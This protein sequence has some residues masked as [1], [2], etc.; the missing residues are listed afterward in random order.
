MKGQRM[1]TA[2]TDLR[3]AFRQ[4]RRSPALALVAV[5]SLALGSGANSAVFSVVDALLL[6]PLPYAQ[7]DQLMMVFENDSGSPE[8]TLPFSPPDFFDFQRQARSFSGLEGC[9]FWSYNIS[10]SGDPERVI[11]GVVTAGLFP[12]L[13]RRP[14]LGRTFRPEEDQPGGPPVVMLGFGLWQRRFG[15]DPAVL[16][17]KIQLDNKPYTI[18]GVMPAGFDFPQQAEIWTLLRESRQGGDRAFQYLRGVGRL[19]PGVSVATARAEVGT[20]ARRLERAYP[21]TNRG[22]GA[23]LIPLRERLVGDFRAAL[24]I[25]FGAV[26]LLL[27]V[28]CVNIANLLLARAARRQGEFAVRGALG[29]GKGRLLRQL[30]TESLLLALAGGGLGLLLAR[31]LTQVL[32]KLNPP[33]IFLHNGEPLDLRGATVDSRVLAFTLAVAVGAGILFGLAPALAARRV[34]LQRTLAAS[35]DRLSGSGSR[36]F[37][38]LAAAEVAVTFTLLIGAGLVLQSFLRL[39]SIDPGFKPDHLLTLQLTLPEGRYPS[40]AQTSGFVAQVLERCRALPGV[41]AAAEMSTL[42]LSNGM[43][44]DTS[45]TVVGEPSPSTGKRESIL[46]RAVSPEYFR[47]VGIPLRA[48]RPLAAQDDGRAPLAVAVNESLARRFFGAKSPIGRRIALAVADLGP[49]G[50]YTDAPREVVAVVGDVKDRRLDADSH[51]EVYLPVAQ[52]PWRSLGFVV[53]T[54]GDPA[55]MVRPVSRQVWAVDPN[56]PLY[57]VRTMD[58]IVSA[59]IAQPRFATV[60]LSAFAVLAIFLAIIGIYGVLSY[61][62]AQRSRELG[63]RMALGA[64]PRDVLRHVLGWS[65]TLVAGGIAV[66]LVASLALT[67]LLRSLVFGVTTTDVPTFLGVTVLLTAVAL[68]A[69]LVPAWRASRLSPITTLRSF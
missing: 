52:N 44:V 21:D 22:R 45:L 53:R 38:L 2:W 11:G 32:V 48:G 1:Q 39:R 41:E 35:G 23:V 47:T 49:I 59:S 19:R 13:G 6:R 46:M 34:D 68:S 50:T 51:A 65:A 58:D 67:R 7:P 29:A 33:K 40:L 55:A 28:A 30:V 60:A 4:L 14:V 62:V 66:G 64:L 20:I 9:H 56:L 63:L 36:L 61:A 8:R 24:L 3:F 12:L 18:V 27:A 57:N 43:N 54:A 5:L 16:G 37:A 25:V 15:A 10:G 69:G 42:P 31:W 26:F 17:S